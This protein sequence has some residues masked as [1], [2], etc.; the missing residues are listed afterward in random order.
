MHLRIKLLMHKMRNMISVCDLNGN[1]FLRSI[2][3]NSLFSHVYNENV[4]Y[5]PYTYVCTY[6]TITQFYRFALSSYCFIY[7]V[8]WS[9]ELC[10]L[11]NTHPLRLDNVYV[12]RQAFSSH[13]FDTLKIS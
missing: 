1:N 2:S 3:F 11:A 6:I 9:R 8:A 7:H 4:W 5:G 10:H 12:R 13:T